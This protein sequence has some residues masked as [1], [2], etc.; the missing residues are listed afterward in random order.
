[1]HLYP[2]SCDQFRTL[3]EKK[4]TVRVPVA[5]PGSP[6]HRYSDRQ[7]FKPLPP[8]LTDSSI[9]PPGNMPTLSELLGRSLS[10]EDLGGVPLSNIQSGDSSSPSLFNF[11]GGETAGLARVQEYFFERDCLKEYFSTRN[12]ML[13]ADYSSK[14]SAW[15]AMGCLSA[16]HIAAEV[17][18]YEA[19]RVK[20]KET[21]WMLFELIFR[22]YFR[23]YTRFHAS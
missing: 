11:I 19:E 12:G 10:D 1:M 5:S 21:Y 13:G 7:A 15:L 6:I 2:C 9:F 18:R 17:R 16:R 8:V 14:F 22:D 23:Y 3:V 4:S 20:S